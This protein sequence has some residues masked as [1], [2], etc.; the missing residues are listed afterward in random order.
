MIEER[1]Y[2]KDIQVKL[3][4]RDRR[5]VRRWCHNNNVRILSDTGTSKQFVLNH[6]FERA[7][8]RKYYKLSNVDNPPKGTSIRDPNDDTI[9]EYCV[10]GEYEKK[11]LSIFTNL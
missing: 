10:K 5:S 8:T 3:Q 2:I 7:L 9:K 1:V 6:E 4:Y 11:S